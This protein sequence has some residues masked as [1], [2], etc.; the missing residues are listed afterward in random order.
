MI[1]VCNISI[2]VMSEEGNLTSEGTREKM[3]SVLES[4]D[5]GDC[6]VKL[7]DKTRN[8]LQDGCAE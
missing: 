3:V 6:R 5:L 7:K 1:C 4:T 2:K 8:G